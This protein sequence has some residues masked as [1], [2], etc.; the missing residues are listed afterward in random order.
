MPDTLDPMK[1]EAMRMETV[2]AKWIAGRVVL[3]CWNVDRQLRRNIPV[4][5]IARH[6]LSSFFSFSELQELGEIREMMR[7]VR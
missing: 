4:L 1:A 2:A 3:V 5:S 6:N 7:G